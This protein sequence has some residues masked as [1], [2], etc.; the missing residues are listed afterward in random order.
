MRPMSVLQVHRL[1]GGGRPAFPQ[2]CYVRTTEGRTKSATMISIDEDGEIVLR[3][4]DGTTESGI[5]G[6]DEIFVG[7]AP[8]EA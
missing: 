4:P 6:W 3:Y 7:E 5:Y 8:A 2:P 1:V